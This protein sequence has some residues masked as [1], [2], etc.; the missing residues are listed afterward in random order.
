MSTM[1]AQVN[2]DKPA[3]GGRSGRRKSKDMARRAYQ[4]KMI[5]FAQNLDK[6]NARL[7]ETKKTVTFLNDAERTLHD[8][9]VA[10]N[11]PKTA[12]E[13]TSRRAAPAVRPSSAGPRPTKH[14]TGAEIL[15]LEDRAPPGALRC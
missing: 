15:A 14:A 12:M 1:T 6:L 5:V 2:G 9:G 8:R 3:L 11:R 10:L 7:L 13:R 4:K